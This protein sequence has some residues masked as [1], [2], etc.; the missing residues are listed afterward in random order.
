[1][2]Q[3]QL[4]VALSLLV[5]PN[6]P[7]AG[8]KHKQPSGSMRSKGRKF[9]AFAY[10]SRRL[11]SEGKK[12]IAGTT[13]AA[14]PRVLPIGTRVRITEAG[15]YSG[16]YTVSDTGGA[17]KGRKIDVFVRNYAEA[18][19]FGRKQVYVAV[20]DRPENTARAR[21]QPGKTVAE[22]SGCGRKQLKAMITVDEAARSN[23]NIPSRLGA[24][25]GMG[26]SSGGSDSR[27][28]GDPSSLAGVST[29]EGPS[30]N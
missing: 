23:R 3:I 9:L 5:A 4:L 2:R 12:P 6:A 30:L 28:A 10:T 14:D 20:L 7:S 17:I 21:R 29:L 25:G 24:T 11:T 26:E 19:Q 27:Q 22:C 13:I 18:R 8:D 15:G 1:V 16:I